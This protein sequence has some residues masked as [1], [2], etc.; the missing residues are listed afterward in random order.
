[1]DTN[2]N[3]SSMQ[4]KLDEGSRRTAEAGASDVL[5]LEDKLGV[6]EWVA[7]ADEREEEMMGIGADIPFG[8][9]AAANASDARSGC[10]C[11]CGE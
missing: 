5:A 9:I 10:I 8:E 1:M 11:I 3:P 6:V 2:T 4:V 7:C